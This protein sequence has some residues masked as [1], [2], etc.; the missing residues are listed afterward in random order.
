M[1]G[2]TSEVRYAEIEHETA[3]ARVQVVL[4]LD[5]GTR[6][7]I[8][9][10]IATLD[11]FLAQMAFFAGFDLG[12]HC[13][14]D[15]HLD[16]HHSVEAVGAAFGAA[17]CLALSDTGPVERLGSAHGV[18]DDAIALVAIDLVG[19]GSLSFQ[20][21]FQREKLGSLA[22]Q[23]IHQFLRSF[24]Q[25]SKI[26]LHVQ[27][28]GGQNDHHLA[29]AIFKGLGQALSNATRRNEHHRTPR[30]NKSRVD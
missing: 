28:L 23:S 16:D 3:H 21:D 5:G 8:E 10:G 12:L 2:S 18:S 22:T 1:A 4:D 15:A 7:D 30:P 26:T 6:R 11:H 29:D 13:D 27:I 14:S 9:T 17:L 25:H 24:S 20:G 19:H